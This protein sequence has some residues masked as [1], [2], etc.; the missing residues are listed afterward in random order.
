VTLPLLSPALLAAAVLYIVFIFEA[1]EI[2]GA[3]GLRSGL[4]VFATEV[5]NATHPAGLALPDYGRASALSVIVM[6]I[7][8]GLLVVYFRATHR[9]SSFTTITGRGYRPRRIQL[10]MWRYPAFG[11]IALYLFLS[12][13]LVPVVLLWVSLQPFYQ[14][15][16]P[17]AF[18]RVSLKAYTDILV[19]PNIG[20]TM[21]NTIIL[22]LGAA[23]ATVIVTF[24]VA[25]VVVRTKIPGRRI[26][27]GAA[28]LPVAIPG[29]VIGLAML[30]LHLGLKI[31]LY[32]T[33]AIV[34]VG[35][36]TKYLAFGTRTMSAAYIQ[37]HQEL[38]EA[39]ALSGSGLGSTFRRVS[40]PLLRP[41]LLNAWV[42][43][44]LHAIRELPVAI[45]LY[46]P[47]SVVLATL[48]WHLWQL[49]QTAVAGALGV[50]LFSLSLLVSIAMRALTESRVGN[51][52]AMD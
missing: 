13:I 41:A 51:T 42:W 25:W 44:F 7:A 28:F 5:Y 6:V 4:T 20:S 31:P 24:G 52:G 22:G 33:I 30:F 39:A 40:L 27:D 29:V 3:I 16:S 18:A 47:G 26:F 9:S 14:I 37:I 15:P 50:V 19:Y 21:V 46:A 45:M 48:L 38:E 10:G 49:G 1:F 36:T 35:L 11:I 8:V 17:A 12:V 32:G 34:I 2:P 23:T 43:V